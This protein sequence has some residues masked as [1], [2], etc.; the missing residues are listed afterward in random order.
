M[1]MPHPEIE[2]E[3]CLHVDQNL[4]FEGNARFSLM[5]FC[6]LVAQKKCDYFFFVFQRSTKL[7]RVRQKI[8]N[9]S[10]VIWKKKRYSK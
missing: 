10:K 6:L 2:P 9:R 3:H 1:V 4:D 5:N 8:R 7:D